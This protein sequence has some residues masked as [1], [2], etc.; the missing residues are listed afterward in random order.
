MDPCRTSVYLVQALWDEKESI[1]VVVVVVVFTLPV[2]ISK[3]SPR[4]ECWSFLLRV[5]RRRTFG[6]ARLIYALSRQIYRFAA[7]AELWEGA[8]WPPREARKSRKVIRWDC[9]GEEEVRMLSMRSHA[10]GVSINSTADWAEPCW[11]YRWTRVKRVCEMCVSFLA[12]TVAW[13]P[14]CNRDGSRNSSRDY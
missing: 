5:R 3:V 4:S 14:R 7:V 2:C 10:P 11:M 9:R 6:H 1:V 13:W 8:S 12:L